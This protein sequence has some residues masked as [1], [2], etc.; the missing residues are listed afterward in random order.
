MLGFWRQNTLLCLH[1]LSEAMT[2]KKNLER[3]SL[4]FNKHDLCEK[5]E[6]AQI[7][8]ASFKSGIEPLVK[9]NFL[10]ASCYMS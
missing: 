3:R 10:P 6:R 9:G 7:L 1:N 2:K 4:C 5:L 8:G